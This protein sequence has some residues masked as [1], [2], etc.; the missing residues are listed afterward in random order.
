MPARPLIALT[1]ALALA[2]G[3]SATPAA[4]RAQGPAYR[5]DTPTR[6][7]LYRDGP[8]DRYLL[9]GVWLGRTDR[10][11][12]GLA[13]GYYTD[14]AAT[15]GWAPIT[16]PSAYNAGDLSHQGMAGY[17]GWYRK[18]FVL[19][20]TAFPAATPARDQ[21]W[22]VRFESINYRAQ[23]W[24]NGRMIGVHV[25]AYLPFE[26]DLTGL[27]PGANRL[28]IRVD[29]RRSRSDLPP[30]PGGNWFNYGGIL[31][32]VYLRAVDRAELQTVQVRP[33]LA[34][35]RCAATIDERVLVRNVTERRQSVR[36]T[37]SYGATALDFGTA[38]IAPGATWTARATVAI[39]H[40]RL[41]SPDHPTLYRARLTL[42]G[43][44]GAR[45]GGYFTY[46][47]I[48]SV[49][50]TPDGRLELNG[51][52]LH[53]RGAAFHE[54]DAMLGSALDS[55][56][57]QRLIGW[58][59]RL[60]AHLIRVHYPLHP[61][62]QE[63]ADQYGI[64][65]WSEVPVYQLA[66]AYLADPGVLGLAQTMLRTNILTNQNHPSVLVWSV[67]NEL[68]TP[69]D[70]PETAYIARA[71]ALVHRLDPTRPV[72]MAVSDWPGI[73]CQRAYGPLDVVGFNDY[74]G[75]FDAGAGATADRE[76]LGPFLDSFRAC[77]PRKALFVTEFG[78]DANRAGPI[79]EHGTYAFQA[80]AA[81]YH[82]RVF[83]TKPWLA[84]AVY[85]VLQDYV[86]N[87]SYSGGNPWPDP[88]Y[89]RKGLVS[90][91]G[92]LKPAFAVVAAAYHATRQIA[93]F[94]TRSGFV[95][96]RAGSARASR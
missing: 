47:G 3:A 49:T 67:G 25:G 58:V 62:I 29:N 69:A 68:A 4:A 22:I 21:H 36:L 32:E 80:D 6:G 54:S 75:W 15:D 52:L 41:W 84:G 13:A 33:I 35:P 71:A 8:T 63:L 88:P 28:V 57:R 9:G 77:Y 20:A 92:G 40:P 26:L 79:E 73:G 45:L 42:R 95:R 34:C 39:A 83:A 23:V 91:S 44:D 93:P 61:E 7:A 90:L 51:R 64:L 48:R 18:D 70:A 46:S 1:V 89:N 96:R 5:A 2:P 74:F 24:L 27:R 72:G 50:V 65:V 82:L 66:S 11:D 59:R 56:H 10:T 53:L 87:P 55:A 31:R 14:V 85:W 94:A 60:G 76:Q 38:T 81:A 78:F 86:Q 43:R 37:G 30:G 12:T 16:V 17:V 19:P